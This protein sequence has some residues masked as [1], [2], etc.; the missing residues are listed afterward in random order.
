MSRW[1]VTP[2]AAVLA[3]ELAVVGHHCE[4]GAIEIAA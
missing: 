3:E 1:M 2:Q 4:D